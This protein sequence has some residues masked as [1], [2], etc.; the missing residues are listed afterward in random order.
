MTDEPMTPERVQQHMITAQVF[1]ESPFVLE[2]C[3]SWLELHNELK[4]CQAAMTRWRLSGCV[5]TKS[6]KK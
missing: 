6:E 1:G 2:L 5:V 4:E 3:R